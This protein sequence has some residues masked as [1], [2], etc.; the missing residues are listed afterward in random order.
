M[1]ERRGG[2]TGATVVICAYTMRRWA[3]LC[4]AVESVEAQRADDATGAPL[5]DVELV[6][7]VDHEPD[8]LAH[9]V[10]RWPRHRVVANAEA[11]GLSGA[12]NTGVAFARGEVVAFLDD[13]AFAEPHWLARL[14]RHF[15]DPSVAGVG[16]LVVPD[17]LDDEPTWLPPEFG[18]VVG[19]SYAGQPAAL[20]EVRNPIGAGMAFRRSVFTEVGGFHDGVGRVG[21]TPLGCEET[22]LS[23][24]ARAA[25]GRVLHDPS[26]IVHH[27][28]PRDRT[29]GRYFV[30]RCWA[31][32]LSK[33]VVTE[34]AGADAGLSSERSYVTRTIPRGVVRDARAAVRG[35]DRRAG[36]VRLAALVGGTA[37]T[38]A[39][40]VRGT[41]ARRGR[42][43]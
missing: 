39:G 15:A 13:D 7:V 10:D 17:W 38:S 27:S 18:W 21:T 9:A 12:R 33:A 42:A 31:E 40:F 1:S 3:Q 37:V 8:L 30:H 26:A 6:V 14:L 4:R 19:C 36:L 22:E 24:R 20:A 11:R 25:G 35:P 34:L 23:I 5:G 28:V 29:S 41:V 16:G 2:P 43:A 32:G